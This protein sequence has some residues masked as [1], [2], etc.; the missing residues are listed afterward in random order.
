MLL[1]SPNIPDTGNSDEILHWARS[2]DTSWLLALSKDLKGDKRNQKSS[3]R[4]PEVA[5]SIHASFPTFA[6]TLHCCYALV[7]LCQVLVSQVNNERNRFLLPTC[8]PIF[9]HVGW[10][11]IGR[12]QE[13]YRIYNR[14]YIQM[15]PSGSRKSSQ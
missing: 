11:W 8:V 9:P 5:H 15:G 13:P 3:H 2:R 10:P 1:L 12:P 7:C 14:E 6:Y 4:V